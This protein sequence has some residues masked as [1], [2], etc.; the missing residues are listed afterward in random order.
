MVPWGL[1]LGGWT[2]I[3]SWYLEVAG[4]W[5]SLPG[6]LGC[7]SAYQKKAEP[8]NRLTSEARISWTKIDTIEKLEDGIWCNT[9]TENEGWR[10][11]PE[12][13]MW[14]GIRFLSFCQLFR[15]QL[16]Y[17][18]VANACP[19]IT[20]WSNDVCTQIYQ[21]RSNFNQTEPRHR[22]QSI[23]LDELM[24]YN[25]KPKSSDFAWIPSILSNMSNRILNLSRWYLY[26]LIVFLVPTLKQSKSKSWRSPCRG[27]IGKGERVGQIKIVHHI[28][29]P[30]KR[31]V[32]CQ[33]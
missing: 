14:D 25:N 8:T 6:I 19:D 33:T 28:C 29:S 22:I 20:S 9:V 26:N 27:G 7:E 16:S 31:E 11:N 17:Q 5:F 10:A 18:I 13:I 4:W 32:H 30:K 21:P 2:Q 15:N 24:N 12:I 3:P 23:A 1:Q